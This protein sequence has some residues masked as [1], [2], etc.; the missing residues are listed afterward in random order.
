MS[1]LSKICVLILILYQNQQ[2]LSLFLL[3]DFIR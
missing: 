1:I 2:A 3:T